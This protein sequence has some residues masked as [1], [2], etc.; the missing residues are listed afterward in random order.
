M[1]QGIFIGLGCI[2]IIALLV[3]GA[4]VVQAILTGEDESVD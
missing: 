3:Y 4:Q 1:I 2:G